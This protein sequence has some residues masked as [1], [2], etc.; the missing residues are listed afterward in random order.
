MTGQVKVSPELLKESL[1][2]AFGDKLEFDK[3]MAPLTTYGTGGPARCFMVVDSKGILSE[4]VKFAGRMSVP[5]FVMGGGSNLL[6]SDAGFDGFVVKIDIKGIVIED[7]GSV[8]SGAGED[9]QSLV[10]FATEN[11]LSGLEFAA[12][13]WGTVG[14]AIYGNAGAFG[15]EIKD[16]LRTITLVDREG[17]I[18]T[19]DAAG[20][21]FGYRDSFLKKS[22]EIVVEA[23]FNLNASD[24]LSIE[25]RVNDILAARKEKHPTQG[26]SAGCF[27]KNIPDLEQEHGKLP[28]GR[29]LEQAGVK[30][31]SVG[32]AAVY[33]KHANM[34]V[35]TG[36]A[37]SKDI[38]QLADIMKKQVQIKFGIELEEE[39]IQL[40]EF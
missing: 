31:L 23:S 19:V 11:S 16:I 3:S 9:L 39:V 22:G 6:V 26:K 33:E 34:I 38:R 10:D 30:G 28:A 29:L 17:S 13:I 8:R 15:G 36:N 37:T 14:G 24:K 25:K 21:H 5:F 4:A 2:E 27:F 40:G 20:C 18:K 1:L 35:N 32:G 12:G 7:G